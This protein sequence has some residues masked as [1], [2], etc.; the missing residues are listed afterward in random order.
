MP[1]PAAFRSMLGALASPTLRPAALLPIP[2][3]YQPPNLGIPVDGD[4][5]EDEEEDEGEGEE[6]DE[7]VDE[8]E[9]LEGE[10]LGAAAA[11]G[12]AGGGDGAASVANGD[13]GIG[14]EGG[15][16]GEVGDVAVKQEEGAGG[17]GEERDAERSFRTSEQ[18]GNPAL[19]AAEVI[20]KMK[21]EKRWVGDRWS[22]GGG[23]FGK[24]KLGPG[25]ADW[26]LL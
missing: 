19:K 26:M 5:Y 8:G 3:A 23:A 20:R 13:E 16:Q 15:V 22:V 1:N 12:P 21:D 6:G 14:M 11:A 18:D 10:G 25:V 4:E 7:G 17:A 24:W 9:G 2:E